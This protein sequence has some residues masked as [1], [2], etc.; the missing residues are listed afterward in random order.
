[1]EWCEEA[2]CY[3]EPTQSSPW[4]LIIINDSDLL[5]AARESMIRRKLDESTIKRRMNEYTAH[6]AH[7]LWRCTN[8]RKKRPQEKAEDENMDVPSEEQLA[9]KSTEWLQPS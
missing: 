5:R 7:H 2:S 4:V 3:H 1:M 9:A 6:V 8:T